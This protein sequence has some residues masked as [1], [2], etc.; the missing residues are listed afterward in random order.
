[1]DPQREA[2]G[3][4]AEIRGSGGAVVVP[5]LLFG[6]LFLEA[7]YRQL[8]QNDWTGVF[9]SVVARHC[10]WGGGGGR[11]LQSCGSHP[12]STV[13]DTQDVAKGCACLTMPL[14]NL[15]Q[16]QESDTCVMRGSILNY[17]AF[18]V[19]AELGRLLSTVSEGTDVSHSTLAPYDPVL[20]EN[21]WTCPI[22]SD[23]NELGGVLPFSPSLLIL[24]PG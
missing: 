3:P 5:L 10:A 4:Q 24:E 2:P 8:N 11:M 6:Q 18:G 12:R 7:E 13:S 23:L 16:G 21:T 15:S 20:L 1:M 17:N 22:L 9:Q 14:R 19:G